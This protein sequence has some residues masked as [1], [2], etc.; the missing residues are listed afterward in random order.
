MTEESTEVAVQ[1]NTADAMATYMAGAANPFTGYSE[2]KG[3]SDAQGFLRFSGNTGKWT[4]GDTVLDDDI[5]FVFNMWEASR[6]WIGW[7]NGKPIKKFLVKVNTGKRPPAEHEL[8]EIPIIKEMDGYQEVVVVL[9]RDIDCQFKQM[10][11]SL[12]CGENWRPINR[13]VKH[14][15]AEMRMHPDPATGGP[16]MPIYSLS[17]ESFDSKG[18]V[19]HAPVMKLIDWIGS[20]EMEDMIGSSDDSAGKDEASAPAKEIESAAAE[21]VD[22]PEETEKAAKAE[23]KSSG[24]RGSFRDQR[25]GAKA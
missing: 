9:V 23:T 19:K 24:K 6:G 11:L 20:D 5:E 4:V 12:P 17:S 2:E 21:E 16:M 13:I 25:R 14:F 15:G 7:S 18:G 10:E 1:G 22:A 8:P 3:V